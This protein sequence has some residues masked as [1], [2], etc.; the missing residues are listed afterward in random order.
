V[1]EKIILMR[2][3]RGGRWGLGVIKSF[4]ALSDKDRSM[5]QGGRTG[6][7]PVC[8][9]ARLCALCGGPAIPCS[10]RDGSTQDAR[11]HQIVFLFAI[12]FE[13]PYRLS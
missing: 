9:G 6:F 10:A 11:R 1:T 4:V 5:I 2:T 3:T 12:I 8:R 13:N 7:Q